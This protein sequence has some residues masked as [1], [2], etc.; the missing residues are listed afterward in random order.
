MK[1]KDL[2]KST[3][4]LF[5]SHENLFAIWKPSFWFYPQET[6]NIVVGSLSHLEF[7]TQSQIQV[8]EI[9]WFQMFQRKFQV[10]CVNGTCMRMCVC[11]IRSFTTDWGSIRANF[12]LNSEKKT[13]FTKPQL[14][15]L[16]TVWSTSTKVIGLL[17]RFKIRTFE[18]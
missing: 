16:F 10:S 15:E 12:T 8:V 1:G 11:V 3:V 13:E 17:I 4:L 6:S 18:I 9:L 7:L 14:I 2:P 5:V